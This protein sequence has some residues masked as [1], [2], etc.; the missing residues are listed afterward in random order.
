MR[1]TRGGGRIGLVGGLRGETVSGLRWSSSGSLC[2]DLELGLRGQTSG[3]A[4]GLS[5]GVREAYIVAAK[6]KRGGHW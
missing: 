2:L 6:A 3:I 5:Y 1:R 4:A